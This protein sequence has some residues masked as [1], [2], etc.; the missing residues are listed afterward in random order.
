[1]TAQSTL[2]RFAPAK[3][4]LFLHVGAKRSD[5]YHD[6]RSLIVFADAGDWLTAEPASDL[7]LDV[8]GPF[9]IGLGGTDDNL[10]L[11]AARALKEWAA[12]RKIE[13]PGVTLTL[14]K[15]LPVAS[16]IGGGSSDAAATLLMLA[17]HW[18][19]PIAL[20]ELEQL[21]LSLGADVPACIRAV[22]LLAE[23]IGDIL[24]PS[25][26]LPAFSFVLVNPRVELA[27]ASVFAALR[28]RTGTGLLPSFRGTSAHDFA[29]W[30]DQ[31][32]NDL[33]AP[34][35]Q[36]APVIT[37]VRAALTAIDGCLLSRMSG[38]GATCFGLFA[39]D[40]AAQEAARS[41]SLAHPGW[42]VT[43]AKRYTPPH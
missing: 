2:R 17:Q 36:L 5:G 7:S 14:E 40:A 13:T 4:N 25:P 9:A 8:A 29:L 11:R 1:M 24:R 33:E 34:A 31:L 21:G 26:E 18:A 16:G 30:L 6:L 20:D 27:T 38:S 37:R 3:I 12:A 43:P 42:W 23:G 15:N 28:T 22:P 39:D 19:L 10:V 41:L 35:T 32:S